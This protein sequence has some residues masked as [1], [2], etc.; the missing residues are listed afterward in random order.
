[1]RALQ[2]SAD[3]TSLDQLRKEETCMSSQ[4]PE[5]TFITPSKPISLPVITKR[6]SLKGP[7]SSAVLTVTGLGVYRVYINGKRAGKEYLTPGFNDYDAYVRCQTL[8]V[9]NLLEEDN[10]MEIYLGDG[11]YRGRIGFTQNNRARWGTILMAAARLDAVLLSGEKQTVSTDETWEAFQSPVVFTDIYDGEERNDTLERGNPVPCKVAEQHWNLI[12]WFS[13]PVRVRAELKPVLIHTPAGETVL[14]FGQNMAGIVRFVCREKRGTRI[15]LQFGEVL[16]KGCFYRDNLRSAKAEYFYTSDGTVREIEPFFTFFGFRYVKVEGMEKVNPEDFTALALSSDL[17]MT[18]EV[19]TGH[20]GINQLMHNALWGQMSNFVDVPT[21]CPQRDERLGWTADTQVFVNTAC[22]QMDCKAFY[23]KFMRDMREDQI[24]YCGGD[25]PPYA[26]CLKS[27]QM[28]GGAVWADAGTIVPWNVYMFYGDKELLKENWPMMRDYVEYL[29]SLDQKEGG[30]HTVFTTFTFGDWVAQ[31][32]M[33]DQST[34][35]GTESNFI[36][37]CYYYYS[38]NLTAKAAGVLGL[39]E[40]EEKYASLAREVHDALMDEYVTK[41]GRL[42]VDTQTAY[43]LALTFGLYSDEKKLL[44]GF[45]RR[46]MRDFYA[47]KSGFTGTP[48]MLPALFDHGMGE[49]AYRMLLRTSFPGWLYCVNL[50][51]TTIW[52]R[53]N[54][55][56]PDGSIS[57]TGMNS[58]NHYAYGS[59]CEAIY[60]RIMGLRNAAPGWKKAILA[61]HPDG[62]LHYARIRYASA[63]GTWYLSWEIKD[64]GMIRIRAEVPEGCEADVVL[65]DKAEDSSFHVTTGIYDW[66]YMPLRDYLHPYSIQSP[67]LDLLENEDTRAIL[68][69]ELPGWFEEVSGKV[70]EDQVKPVRDCFYN[71]TKEDM[72]RTDRKL[73]AVRV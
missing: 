33:T 32:G 6:F 19:E 58:L 35:G 53:W 63:A 40:E 5:L 69:E 21:D 4:I 61:P 10:L 22:Y 70:H 52:E 1:M 42:A 66:S 59:V 7:L 9:K 26:P 3:T 72:E 51:A 34:F 8:D 12:P 54:S 56:N 37:G 27:E 15:H 14:D 30:T 71:K 28:H 73:R 62:R 24:R 48:L 50:G 25:I 67:V 18:L 36:Q 38:L 41:N 49:Q 68:K 45:R 65:P 11:W 46:F 43:V 13:P 64:D 16:Q 23:R 39:K 31:D 60:S 2:K 17:P 55:L 44:Q 20:K 29:I 57:G 47:I